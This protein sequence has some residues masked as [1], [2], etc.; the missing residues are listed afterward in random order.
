[1][2]NL[3]PRTEYLRNRENIDTYLKTIAGILRNS[4]DAALEIEDQNFYLYMTK[5]LQLTPPEIYPEIHQVIAQ[6]LRKAY[7]VLKKIDMFKTTG[8]M[9]KL[10]ECS[11][12]LDTA[13][14]NITGGFFAWIKY[15]YD[16]DDGDT[17]YIQVIKD[18]Y[19]E[20][21]EGLILEEE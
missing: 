11:A 3:R 21:Y 18:E 16:C 17:S 7:E 2:S 20:M 12:E 8:N 14:S 6:S 19:P 13:L 4:I 15:L 9:S 5:F 1:M 10:D